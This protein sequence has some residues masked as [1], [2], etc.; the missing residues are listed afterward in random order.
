MGMREY[1]KNENFGWVKLN[2]SDF[3][4]VCFFLIS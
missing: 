3:L 1:K 2:F 4:N